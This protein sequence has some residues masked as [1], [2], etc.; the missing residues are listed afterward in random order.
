MRSADKTLSLNS[1]LVS[2]LW[3]ILLSY[4]STFIIVQVHFQGVANCVQWIH[5]NAAE[6]RN[7][8]AAILTLHIAAHCNCN[9]SVTQISKS[10]L[11]CISGSP[12]YFTFRAT[13]LTNYNQSG[14][15]MV[16]IIERWVTSQ[17]YVFVVGEK[18]NIINCAVNTTNHTDFYCYPQDI[19]ELD[20]V[21]LIASL[22][23]FSFIVLILFITALLLSIITFKYWKKR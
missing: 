16:E 11:Q 6:K 2:A 14:G 1:L 17:K 3:I 4:G 18:I 10:T 23:G 7:S 21:A 5:E 22:V 19:P 20:L 15:Y 12:T 13:L 9:F 8:I